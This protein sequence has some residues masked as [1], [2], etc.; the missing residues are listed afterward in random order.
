MPPSTHQGTKVVGLKPPRPDPAGCVD[1]G[2]PA[3]RP[4]RSRW[5][6]TRSSTSASW[7]KVG[8]APALSCAMQVLRAAAEWLAAQRDNATCMAWSCKR[9]SCACV[10]CLFTTCTNAAKSVTKAAPAASPYQTRMDVL[11]IF[12]TRLATIILL[13]FF[14]ATMLMVEFAGGYPIVRVPA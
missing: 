8:A 14:P 1:T 10:T 13:H 6:S 9:R 3:D 7:V 11:S 4:G 2:C 5:S 12:S